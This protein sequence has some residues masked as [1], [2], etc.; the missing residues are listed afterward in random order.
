MA[1]MYRDEKLAR[2]V[3]DWMEETKGGKRESAYSEKPKPKKLNWLDQF[4]KDAAD[5]QRKRIDRITK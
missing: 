3:E 4:K 5:F 1:S 2:R